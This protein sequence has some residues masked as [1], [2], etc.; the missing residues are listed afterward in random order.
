ME[1]CGNPLEARGLVPAA[2]DACSVCSGD[3]EDPDRTAWCDEDLVEEDL[4][5][6]VND[7]NETIE[8]N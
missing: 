4:F 1:N 2:W 8:K 3:Y 6:E 5:D 7:A